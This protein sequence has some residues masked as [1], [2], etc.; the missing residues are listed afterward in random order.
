MTLAEIKAHL[1][2]QFAD[3]EKS[4]LSVEEIKTIVYSESDIT[5]QLEKEFGVESEEVEFAR[6]IQEELFLKLKFDQ[7]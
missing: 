3:L 2:Q 1:V 5:D 6:G 7:Q 4:N